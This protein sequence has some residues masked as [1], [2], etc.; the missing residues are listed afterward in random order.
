[1][2]RAGRYLPR[3]PPALLPPQASR[4]HHLEALGEYSVGGGAIL[5][6]VVELQQKGVEEERGKTDR[7]GSNE[8]AD[9]L[10]TRRRFALQE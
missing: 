4:L 8:V 7:F 1:M 6:Q 3:F 9:T 2:K 10:W 5:R